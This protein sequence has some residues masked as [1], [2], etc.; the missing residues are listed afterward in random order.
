MTTLLSLSV[1]V[2]SYVITGKV[3]VNAGPDNGGSCQLVLQSSSTVLDQS[4]AQVGYY[5]SDVVIVNS[6]AATLAS[7]D[8]ILL[9][10]EAEGEASANG[11]QLIAIQVAA[12]N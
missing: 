10:C 4:Q 7:A 12:L 5:A 8:T 1:P 9:Q 6:A 11:E 2:G 3:V